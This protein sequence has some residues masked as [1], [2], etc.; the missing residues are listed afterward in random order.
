MGRDCAACLILSGR[1]PQMWR[2]HSFSRNLEEIGQ[3]I[4]PSHYMAGMLLEYLGLRSEVLPNFAPRPEIARP[5]PTTPHFVF[6]GVL[7]KHKGLDIL[8]RA[9]IASGVE[10]ELHVLGRGSLEQ[11]VDACASQT[12]G[13]VRN[14]GFLQRSEVLSELS[15]ALCLVTPSSCRENSPLV[16]IEALSLGVP[17]LVSPRGGLPELVSGPCG[18]VADLTVDGLASALRMFEEETAMRNTMAA[19]ARRRYDEMHAPERYIAHYLRL[20]GGLS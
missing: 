9:Y 20:A 13:K 14:R 6:A 2:D 18:L 4:A 10:A 12:G 1:P 8:L 11:Q 15:S 5:G 17:L 19:N 7:E 16:C 3:T